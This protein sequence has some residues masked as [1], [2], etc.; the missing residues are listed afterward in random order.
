MNLTEL[1]SCPSILWKVK[2]VSDEIEYLAEDV[3][4]QCVEEVAWF[5]LTAYSKM[6]E[7]RN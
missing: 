6:R 4:K 7:E 2:L 5:L 1:C 3:S